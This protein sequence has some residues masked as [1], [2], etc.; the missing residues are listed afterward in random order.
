MA[1]RKE[2]KGNHRGPF[3]S[4]G[5]KGGELR[6][7]EG[8][9]DHRRPAPAPEL[10]GEGDQLRGHYPPGTAVDEQ[11]QGGRRQADRELLE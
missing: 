10:G 2:E 6:R 3:R 4:G 9:Q 7:R 1:A 8:L 5:R 11:H